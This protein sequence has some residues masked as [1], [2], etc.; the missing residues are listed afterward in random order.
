MLTDV[1]IDNNMDLAIADGDFALGDA[2]G[3]HMQM[4]IASHPGEW[5]QHPYAGVGI[6]DYL[7]GE[8]PGGLKAEIKRQLKADGMNVK[9]VKV[10]AN[11][12]VNIDASY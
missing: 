3:Q 6:A 10:A 7:K 11:G 4:L 9:S 5:K 2:T 12:S 1:L 8:N